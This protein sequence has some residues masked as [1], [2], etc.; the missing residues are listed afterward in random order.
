MEEKT[1]AGKGLAITSL[2]LG[3]LS[4]ICLPYIIISI[5]FAVGSILFGICARN[6]GERIFSKSGITLGIVSLIITL[7]LF[8]FLKVFDV[9]SLFIIPDWYNK[10]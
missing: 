3:I 8:L 10:I 5:G 1:Q 4:I 7:I 9:S 6:K 2:V